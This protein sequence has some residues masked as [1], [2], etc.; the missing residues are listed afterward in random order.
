MVRSVHAPSGMHRELGGADYELFEVRER[1][2][3]PRV[4]C[5]KQGKSVLFSEC[6][7][8][9]HGATVR[10]KGATLPYVLCP[11]GGEARIGL[12]PWPPEPVSAI[13]T[14]AVSVAP[15]LSVEKLVRT[16][17]EEDLTAAPVVGASGEPIGMVTRTDVL[18]DEVGWTEL[19]DA[20]LSSWPEGTERRGAVESEDELWVHDLLRDRTVGDVM[21]RGVVWVAADVSIR[22]AAEVMATSGL[23]HLLVVDAAGRPAGMVGTAELARWLG[24]RC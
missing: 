1:D 5:P 19:R 12:Q 23:Q 6:Q 10:V 22:A 3:A 24:T 17:I 21:T 20:A 4:D 11:S 16:F 8:C 7:G 14:K 18:S 9:E 2:G 13:M 15:G